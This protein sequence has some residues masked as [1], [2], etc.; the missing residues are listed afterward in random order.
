[1]KWFGFSSSSSKP[2]SSWQIHTCKLT[3]CIPSNGATNDI[4]IIIT[5][6]SSSHPS[7]P[8]YHLHH[9]QQHHHHNYHHHHNH[10]HQHH[11]H[12]HHHHHENFLHSRRRHKRRAPVSCCKLWVFLETHAT[13]IISNNSE[14]N[15]QQFW[16]RSATILNKINNNS[17]QDQQQFWP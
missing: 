8:H 7:P 2:F 15:Q 11:Q 1:M 4:A 12:H 16:T 5:K 3:S 17:K 13:I 6:P 14:Q 10:Q 9:Y